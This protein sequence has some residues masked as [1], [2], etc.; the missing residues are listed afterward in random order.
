L[1][2]AKERWIP[3]VNRTLFLLYYLKGYD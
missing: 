3:D 1:C 2:K